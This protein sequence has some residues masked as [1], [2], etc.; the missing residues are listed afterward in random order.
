MGVTKTY[1]YCRVSTALQANEG[2]SLDVQRRKIEGRALE[3]GKTLDHVF[4]E[5]GV[6]GSKPLRERPQ[7][8]ALL[9]TVK[10]GDTVIASKLDRMFRSAAD[11]LAVLEE[12]KRRKIS[13][14]LLDLGGDCTSDGIARLVFTILSAAAE[15]ERFRTRERVLET[16]ADRRKR[17]LAVGGR[18]P[19]GWTIGP[20]GMLRPLPDEQ[21]AIR[22]I[23]RLRA[24]GHSLRTIA[25]RLK[26]RGLT[27]SHMGVK[28]ALR[29]AGV[30]KPKK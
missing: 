18:P 29:R 20:G 22:F 30:P 2:E 14:Y 21:A 16:V 15:F 7:G 1:G 12:F 25:Q 9:D 27:I 17:G 24:N 28:A 10:L 23:R 19:L 8:K 4:V 11:A 26:Q 5:T 3:L 6:S 13:L